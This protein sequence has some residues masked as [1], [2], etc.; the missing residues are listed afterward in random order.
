MTLPA[1]GAIT[2]SAINKELGKS[3]TSALSLNN[4]YAR[5]LVSAPTG[6]V[7]MNNFHS[8][9]GMWIG[10]L[11]Y[12]AYSISVDG[13]GNVY[14]A[15]RNGYYLKFYLNTGL[16]IGNDVRYGV[17][18]WR[19]K[20]NSDGS[21]GGCNDSGYAMTFNSAGAPSWVI[22]ATDVHG[23]KVRFDNV[24]IGASASNY[25]FVGDLFDASVNTHVTVVKT[26]SSGTVQWQLQ[27]TAITWDTSE[28]S[29]A[30][31]DASDNTFVLSSHRDGSN[32]EYV[33]IMKISSG[34]G[35][36]WERNITVSG[37]TSGAVKPC[38]NT[39]L[40]VDTTGSVYAIAFA[41][42]NS[43][44]TLLK[45]N[46]SGVLQWQLST[47]TSVGYLAAA[48]CDS[49]N[50]VYFVFRDN[51]YDMRIT[52]LNSSGS[53]LWQRDLTNGAAIWSSNIA[54]SVDAYDNLLLAT[55]VIFGSTGYGFIARLP[56]DGGGTGTYTISGN[57]L[58]YVSSAYSLSAGS[59]VDS[60]GTAGLSAASSSIVSSS[61][62][63][64]SYSPTTS[65]AGLNL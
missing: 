61:M 31:I 56:N 35:L 49:S 41:W 40:A 47:G 15:S 10:T 19:L 5:S 57:S 64:S 8:K 22:R 20:A 52:K 37:G 34:G 45:Y 33:N 51:S 1:S 60:A 4:G 62:S 39:T 38:Y 17:S 27:K 26:N 24:L 25:Y 54:L 42:S 9:Y 50:N 29:S 13:N 6:A 2:A 63:T 3:T 36:S 18:T 16:A 23:S 59:L 12:L 55:N 30:G 14:V 58:T 28:T 11:P 65:F 32:N 48:V 53:V 43:V 44:T 46:S 7:S 21:S